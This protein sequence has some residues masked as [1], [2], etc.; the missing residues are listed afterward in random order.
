[1]VSLLN[2]CVLKQGGPESGL[3][4]TEDFSGLV[5]TNGEGVGT[6]GPAVSKGVM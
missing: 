6:L 2:V 4:A 5:G 3:R 1:M